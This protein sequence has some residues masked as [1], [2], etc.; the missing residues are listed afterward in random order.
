MFTRVATDLWGVHDLNFATFR[1]IGEKLQ[2]ITYLQ[3]VVVIY[4]CP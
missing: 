4:A 1:K 3:W 2:K